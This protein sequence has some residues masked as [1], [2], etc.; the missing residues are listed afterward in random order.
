MS[1]LNRDFKDGMQSVS[2]LHVCLRQSLWACFL[3]SS[4]MSSYVLD[5]NNC[6]LQHVGLAQI[7]YPNVKKEKFLLWMAIRPRGVALHTSVVSLT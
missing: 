4:K 7:E 2:V 1:L 6:F 5:L 3:G